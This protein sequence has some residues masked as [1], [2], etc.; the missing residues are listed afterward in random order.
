MQIVILDGY[1][2]SHG[3]LDF[4]ALKQF[5]TVSVYDRTPPELVAQRLRGA[6]AVFINKVRLDAETLEGASSL[7]FIGVL[8]T[9][10]DVVDMGAVK[11]RRIVVC[12]VPAYSTAAVAQAT[13]A[14]LLEITHHV[15]YYSGKIRQ[16]AWSGCPDFSYYECAPV[17]LDGMTLGIVGLG[18]IGSRVAQIGRSL[19]MRVIGHSPHAHPEFAGE[20][21]PLAQLFSES[22]VLSLHC[23]ATA[24]TVGIVN[25]H[26]IAGMKDGAILLNTA[27]GTLLN[28]QD[29]ADA[30]LSGKLAAAG[31]DVAAREP[32]GKS[33]PLLSA[34]NCIITG[35]YAWATR[36]ARER[37]IAVSVENLAAFLRGAPQNVV[38][39]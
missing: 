38:F 2:V 24:Q 27:R 29:V 15:G 12:N 8:A 5:G 10:Y 35:H 16:G 13:I 9:G 20:Q 23:P 4:D 37:L 30:L 14:L 21:V 6:D 22:D 25:R 36:P 32:I 17:E 34:P 33:N 31:L 19:G 3:E 11:R 18:A 1:A 39:S 7:R 28:E 26:T